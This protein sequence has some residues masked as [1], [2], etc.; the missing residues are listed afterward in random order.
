MWG[1][2]FLQDPLA[3]VGHVRRMNWRV[4]LVVLWT[5]VTVGCATDTCTLDGPDEVLVSGYR[6]NEVHRFNLCGEAQGVV[7]GSNRIRGAQATAVG[8]DGLLYVVS[9]ENGRILRY[10][11]DTLAFVD[12]WFDTRSEP[13]VLGAIR[14][15]VALVFDAAGDAYIG[16]YDS[17]E[18][19]RVGADGTVKQT[20][21]LRSAG[22]RGL[23]AGIVF[24]PDGRLLAPGYDSNTIHAVDID[25]E[26]VTRF[27]DA[28][29]GL[30]NPRVILVDGM[31]SRLL[32][33]NEASGEV[34]ILSLD[35]QRQGALLTTLSVTG[36]S[37]DP[38]G[39]L[40]ITNDQT[41]RVSRFGLDGGDKGAIVQ[42]SNVRGAVF[43]S[44]L[45]R[46]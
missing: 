5:A 31:N 9:E 39:D 23:D 6:S 16:G 24:H 29:E 43:L 42:G 30:D 36:M 15:P 26:E 46:P 35:G 2:R 14:R 4:L 1:R 18:I 28:A 22:L 37:F 8:P 44:I 45:P 40:L 17:G 33:S 13:G 3:D 20:Y 12:T 41:N 11:A 10:R 38:A 32:V 19:A 7:D 27:A 25:T 34:V 21:A